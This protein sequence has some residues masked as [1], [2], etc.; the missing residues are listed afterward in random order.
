MAFGRLGTF[1]TGFGRL[2][3]APR[4]GYNPVSALGSDLIAYWDANRSDLMTIGGGGAISSWRDIKAGYDAVQGTGAAQPV[5]SATSFNGAPGVTGDGVDDELTCTTAG[6]LAALP[7]GATPCSLWAVAKQDALPAD[8]TGRYVGGYGS[9]S[10]NDSRLMLRLVS[11]GV[12]RQSGRVGSGAG[13]TFADVTT[14]DFSSRHASVVHVGATASQSATDGV[15]GA[16]QAVV[17]ATTVARL[18]L[19]ATASVV[20]GLFWQGQIAAFLVTKPLDAAKAAALQ[21]YLLSRRRL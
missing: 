1:G 2:G 6:L 17:P 16:S 11:G 13:S 14:V 9:L 7:A 5:W 21:S 18:R 20:A 8:A 12:N 10:A 19:F 3:H 4:T 15:L